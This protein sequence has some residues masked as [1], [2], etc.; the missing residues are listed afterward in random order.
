M[1]VYVNLYTTRTK[2]KEQAR[3]SIRVPE[4]FLPL[5]PPTWQPEMI[6]GDNDLYPNLPPPIFPHGPT[7]GGPLAPI[8]RPLLPLPHPGRVPESLL[9]PT[10]PLVV[11]HPEMASHTR[12]LLPFPGVASTLPT[13]HSHPK[14]PLLPSHPALTRP[15][16]LPQPHAGRSSL[17]Q[18][19]Y[20]STLHGHGA[21]LL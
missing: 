9:G 21:R 10:H 8:H 19:F 15:P 3:G 1:Q 16:L 4:G 20:H 7:L 14:R 6:G 17:N 11:G 18:P 2:V 13:V 12:P 5:H